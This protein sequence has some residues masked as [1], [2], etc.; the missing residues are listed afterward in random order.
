[1]A[2]WVALLVFPLFCL[3]VCGR[4]PGGCRHEAGPVCLVGGRAFSEASA[5]RWH[6]SLVLLKKPS[7][8]PALPAEPQSP[9]VFSEHGGAS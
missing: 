2:Q 7:S 6:T 9:N 5:E 4:S 3:Y 8:D 1:M